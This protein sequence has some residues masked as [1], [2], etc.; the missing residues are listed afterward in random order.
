MCAMSLGRRDVRL[1]RG[2]ALQ[3]QTPPERLPH[4]LLVNLVQRIDMVPGIRGIERVHQ[5]LG[6]GRLV[7]RG[8]PWIARL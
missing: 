7:A 4:R 8:D 2:V 5:R 6:L 3:A 1:C